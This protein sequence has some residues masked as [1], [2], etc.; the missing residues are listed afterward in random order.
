MSLAV[1]NM[2]DVG[3]ETF[4]DEL[5]PGTKLLLGQFTIDSFLNA[6]GFGITY[7]AR[8]SLDRGL[9]IKE[10]FPAS[11]CRRSG[12]VVGPRTR[13]R[14]E[15]YR[16]VVKL[17]LQEAFTLS[18]LDHPNI[19]KVHQVFEDNE[20]AYMAMEYI[21]GPDLLETIEG[22]A[23]ALKPDQIMATL[24]HILDALAYVHAQGVLHRDISPDN[25]LLDRKT[26]KPVLIDFGASRKEMTRK[27]RALSGLRVVKDG[28]SPQEFYI[29]GSI[30]APCSDLYALAASFCHLI[31]GETPKTSQDRLSSIANRQ[32]DPQVAL[33]G[34][35]KGYPPAFLKALD[36]AMSI[37]PRDRFQSVAD[38][39]AMLREGGVLR[40]VPTPKTAAPVAA[41][42][43]AAPAAKIVAA[44]PAQPA[45]AQPAPAQPAAPAP[46]APA[47]SAAQT[48]P[49]A[50]QKAVVSA[51]AP[52]VEKA[53]APVSPPDT[54]RRAGPQI[55][56]GTLRDLL[57]SS[58]A[59]VLLL[60]GL[61]SLPADLMQRLWTGQSAVTA[62]ALPVVAPQAPAETSLV[63]GLRMPFQ[64]DPADP[65]R[66]AARLP[67]S[68][69]WVAP[70]LRVV[71]V[72]GAA[73]QDG[74]DLAAMLAAGADLSQAT[75]L[76]VILGYVA[77]TGGDVIRK[78][79]TLPAVDRLDL[80]NGLSFDMVSTPT[81]VQTV[82]AAVPGGDVTDLAVGDVLVVYSATGEMLGTATALADILSREMQNEI[83]TYGFAIQR[84]GKMAAGSFRLPEPG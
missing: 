29:A 43:S 20:T 62:V 4:A 7:R 60:A 27:S 44:A 78:M 63:R 46:V 76:N 45:L 56:L 40:P 55:R 24:D 22:T 13:Q 18:R 30:Q 33:A 84:D 35:I 59:A 50:P 31:S 26:G 70:G 68:P 8:D 82:V 16:S 77:A 73:V 48:V 79:E 37:F 47:P 10:C 36:K 67:W 2:E 17:F 75:E 80:P 83:A 11:F 52:V 81:S 14:E 39:Q 25:I 23:P 57:V 71:E 6:G 15:E 1:Q 49:E 19:V 42:A 21:D 38:W 54:E 32:G 12:N 64:V 65:A 41:V 72:N 61:L 34:R 28:Y 66:I 74:A 51:P 58:A 9:V 69:S 5:K 53:A 3:L